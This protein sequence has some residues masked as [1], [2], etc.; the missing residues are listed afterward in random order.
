MRL[1]YVPKVCMASVALLLGASVALGQGE[2]Y[3]YDLRFSPA[4]QNFFSFGPNTPLIQTQIG[5]N[6][7]PWVTFGMDFDANGVLFAVNHTGGANANTIGT[8]NLATAAFTPN[9]VITGAYGATAS[10]TD[11]TIDLTTGNAFLSTGTNLMSINL[12]T[13]VTTAIA[14][15]SGSLNATSIV[16]DLAIDNGG[17]MFAHDIATD[18]LHSVDKATGVA[19]LI[20]PSGFAAN[21]AQGMD[22]DPATNILYAAIYTGA[23]TGSYGTWNTTTAAFTTIATLPTFPDPNANGRELELAIRFVSAVPEPTSMALIGMAV[24]GGGVAYRRR[25][26]FT[27]RWMAND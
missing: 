10:P 7:L 18:T 27:A 20:G 5:P 17:N 19:T 16:V 26:Q 4:T 6:P 12:T 14:A 21:F 23:G 1:S 2:V 15:Y 11:M 9:A 3:A 22:F 24:A 13:G 8:V 25:K